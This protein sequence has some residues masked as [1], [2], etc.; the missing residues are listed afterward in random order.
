M[1]IF[2]N[3]EP[4]E[5]HLQSENVSYILTIL[6]NGQPGHLYYG[7][8]LTHRESFQHFVRGGE[9]GATAYLNEGDMNFSLELVQQE[10]PSFG[11]TD[12]REPAIHILQEN[13]SRISGFEYV[14][15]DTVKGKPKLEGLPATYTEDESEASTLILTL[16]DPVTDAELML[17]YTIFEDTGA[18]TR[19]AKVLNN[20]AEPLRIK[21]FMSASVDFPDADFDM[22]QLSGAWVRERHVHSRRL[23]PGIQRVSS[24]RGTSSSQQNPF[25]AMVRPDTNEHTGDVY[26]FSFV[27][28]GNFLAQ[29]EVDHYDSARAMIGLHPFDFEWKLETGES[30]Q[31][32]EAVLVYSSEGMNGMSR[33]YHDLYRKRLARG[34]W[35]DRERPVLIN[36]WEATY[37]DF[38][39][40]KILEIARSAHECGVELFVLDDGWFGRRDDDTTSLGDWVVDERKLPGGMKQLAENVTDL[41]MQFGLWFEPE[42][43]SKESRLFKE[44]PEWVIQAPDRRLSHGRN[45]Y[46]LDFSNR[47]V[48]DHL[49]SQMAAVLEDAPISYVKWDMNRNITE[50]GSAWLPRDRQQELWHRYILGVYELYE[51]LTARF[52]H[53]LFESCASGGARFDPG[54]LYYAPQA[55]TSDNT[56]AVE[57]LKIQYGT[58][59]VY[60]LSSMGAHVSAVPNHQVKRVTSLKTRG[61]TAFFGMFG[62]ELDVT[63]MS[64]TD[65][66]QVKKQIRFYKNY[67]SLIQKGV[68]TRLISPFG[69]N[70]TAWMVTSKDKSTALAGYYQVL[71]EP[72]PG[73]KKLKLAGLD[74]DRK[75]KVSGKSLFYYGDELMHAGLDL[76]E[77]YI[78][79][80]TGGIQDSG[81]FTSQLYVIE[82]V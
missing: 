2:V 21:R 48:V 22:V 66:E 12:F 8:K 51:R 46:V 34:E 78:G 14:K 82:A 24:T 20:G 33:A 60:P 19:S 81:D 43:I 45:Q 62:Y 74:P 9:R 13:G 25:F 28:S 80:D 64:E 18:V 79:T 40:E 32:P 77:P 47:E 71:G 69:S 53:I 61:D 37:F 42:M 67:R 75:Y 1:P 17:F 65:R 27:Y 73:F 57:R 5:F 55:W 35:R 29:V 41:G 58:S 59:F 56:D 16:H 50:A 38:N 23:V 54:M 7:K 31:S 44:H 26:G 10:F 49:F 4:L 3:Q 15:H 76:E 6:E 63:K 52:P 30:F 11:T 70:E 36:N 68:F 72:N 39:E